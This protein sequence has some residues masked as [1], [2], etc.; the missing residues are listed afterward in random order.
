[1]TRA[2]A[3]YGF[4][5][6]IRLTDP[7]D[8]G[9]FLL[10]CRKPPLISDEKND[11]GEY[12]PRM[13]LIAPCVGKIRDESSPRVTK[14]AFP[15]SCKNRLEERIIRHAP[16]TRHDAVEDCDPKCPEM[17]CKKNFYCLSC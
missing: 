15:E 9:G 1:M 12:G 13:Y 6:S 4:M 14:R 7:V 3:I 5:K 2:R 8:K 11:D 17:R 16:C 10:Q